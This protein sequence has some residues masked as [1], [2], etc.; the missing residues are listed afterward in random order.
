MRFG[1]KQVKKRKWMKVVCLIIFIL[2]SALFLEDR[3][4]DYVN[5]RN[6][7]NTSEVL[8]DQVAGIIERNTDDE[9]EMIQS[10]KED[11]MVRAKAVAYILDANEKTEHD[12]PE[13]QKIAKLMSVDEVH[14]FDK[15]GKV[16]SGT[17]PKYYGY[18]FSSG[19]QIAYF[20]PMLKNKKLTMCQDVTPNTSEGK[21][22]MY[23][24]TWNDAGTRMIQVGVEPVRL[25]EKLKRNE[26]KS[27]VSNMPVYEGIDIYVADRKSG[28]IYGATDPRKIGNKLKQL[29]ISKSRSVSRNIDGYTVG[30]VYDM[31]HLN[32]SNAVAMLSVML[33]LLIATIILLIMIAR[34]LRINR[35][36]EEQYAVLATMAG[37]NHSMYV[38]KLRENKIM[39]YGGAEIGEEN[40]EGSYYEDADVRLRA[41]LEN[42][43]AEEY[44][45]AAGEFVDLH[46]LPERMEGEK[47]IS[48]DFIG[49]TLGWFQA[50]FIA[51][52]QDEEQRP[53]SVIFAV[54][55]IEYEKRKEEQL[56]RSST[57]DELTRCY[58]RRAYE[59]DIKKLTADKKFL[60]LSADVNGLKAVND[61]LGHAAGDELLCGVAG[62]MK[63][64]FE[65]YGKVYRIGGDEFVTILFTDEEQFGIIKQ[66][67]DLLVDNWS[68]DTVPHMNVSCGAVWSDERQWE[69]VHEIAKL[70][71]QRMY[72]KKAKHYARRKSDFQNWMYKR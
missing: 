40:I 45:E 44:R 17:V 71:D 63:Q 64:S 21:K 3:L 31:T 24:I 54:R 19:K 36:K 43:T 62:C 61:R 27:V 37:L 41:L 66:N 7:R 68:G 70:A 72:E 58:N 38:I 5:N 18:N 48:G 69:S 39:R 35:E 46:T 56:L 55:S 67:F 15:S 9:K 32:G 13:L 59:Q 22:M 34:V 4:L 47:Y 12:V 42:R 10:L 51:I 29:K 65:D 26:I 14:L 8:L 16:Y 30:V 52:R 23:A 60:Y 49:T 53:L 20:K 28:K 2:I 33:Y 1:K 6:I 11:Y 57:T 25:L 50:S